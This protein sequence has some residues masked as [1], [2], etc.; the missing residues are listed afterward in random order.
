METRFPMQGCRLDGET[1]STPT[2]AP[3]SG[4]GS[5]NT[6]AGR[7]QR[8]PPPKVPSA[9]DVPAFRTH[10]MSVTME[11]SLSALASGVM[12]VIWLPERLRGGIKERRTT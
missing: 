12:S 11:L 10:F 6:Q 8:G 3:D 9:T 5:S 1:V 2:P 4:L 7:N